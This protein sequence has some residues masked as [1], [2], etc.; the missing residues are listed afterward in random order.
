MR[1]LLLCVI[2]LFL[3]IGCQSADTYNIFGTCPDG[4]LELTAPDL[5]LD[6]NG[7]YHMTFLDDYVQTFTTLQA[8]TNVPLADVGW[9]TDEQVLFG[10]EWIHLING[11]SYTDDEGVAYGVLGVWEEHIGDT[12]TVMVN[13]MDICNISY[14]E[15][16]YVIVD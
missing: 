9:S 1:K 14:L 16:L 5:T 6:E 8:E 11:S 4:Y 15:Y 2:S 3:T 10:N 7:Y 12:I 13:Y